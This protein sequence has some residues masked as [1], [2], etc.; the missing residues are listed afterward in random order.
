MAARAY[1][2]DDARCDLEFNVE[3]IHE[4][5]LQELLMYFCLSYGINMRLVIKFTG[6][7]HF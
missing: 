3:T 2:R 5:S 6:G 4:L 7:K 1:K